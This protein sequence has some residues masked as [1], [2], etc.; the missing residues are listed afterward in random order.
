MP[1]FAK[2]NPNFMD[3]LLENRHCIEL[4]Y[5]RAYAA[6]MVELLHWRSNGHGAESKVF[7]SRSYTHVMLV[8]ALLASLGQAVCT[9]NSRIV[10]RRLG[11]VVDL[12]RSAENKSL[13]TCKKIIN[14][15]IDRGFVERHQLSEDKRHSV[16]CLTNIS[17]REWLEFGV[18]KNVRIAQRNGLIEAL[19]EMSQLAENSKSM[20][21]IIDA[22]KIDE[23]AKKQLKN[24][25]KF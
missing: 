1:Q 24:S 2:Q 4:E 13:A 23:M 25:C 12:M 10:G 9:Y 8:H 5:T 11:E 7:F 17:V 19:Q 18:E 21:Q 20:E 14:E 22:A 6:F 16:L 3:A 15:S